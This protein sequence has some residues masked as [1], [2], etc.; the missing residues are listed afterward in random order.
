MFGGSAGWLIEL[1]Y[2]RMAHGRWINPGFLTG[3]CLPLYG[4]GVIVLYAVSSLPLAGIASRTAR[5]GVT[6][7][8]LAVALTLV[9]YLTGLVFTRVFHVKLWDYS[10]RPGNIDGIICTLFSAIWALVA[11][12]YVLFLHPHLTAAVHWLAV[13]P[14]YNFF[15]G[16]YMGIFL[17]DVAYSFHIV[18]KIKAVAEEEGLQIKYENL[19]LS[20]A[21]HTETLKMKRNFVF[22][23]RSRTSLR[24]EIERYV[25]PIREKTAALRRSKSK[26]RQSRAED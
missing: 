12:G 7:A 5:Q 8:I 15:S 16:V 25:E 26:D 6:I 24:D 23:L 18:A 13:N 1:C 22:A 20:I 17:V 3:P 9:E 11:A 4:S 2:R 19:K 14:I 10:R 21:R